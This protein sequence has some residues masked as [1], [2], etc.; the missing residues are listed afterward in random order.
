MRTRRRDETR[1]AQEGNRQLQETRAVKLII[2]QPGEA[3]RRKRKGMEEKLR[4]T[5]RRGGGGKTRT[6]KG[7][8]RRRG[9]G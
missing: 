4:R 9:G 3:K 7:A 1:G 6:G 8:G 5:K 2:R